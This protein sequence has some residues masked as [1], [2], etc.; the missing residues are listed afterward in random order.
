MFDDSIVDMIWNCQKGKHEE[1][2]RTIYNLIQEL[3]P[4]LPLNI[5]DLFFEK[6][7]TLP[8]AQI[9]EKYIVFVREFSKEA[10]KKRFDFTVTQMT[11]ASGDMSQEGYQNQ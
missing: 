11:E 6:I 9:D 5:I 2:V 10:F 3:L 4:H 1:M 7:K 8:P